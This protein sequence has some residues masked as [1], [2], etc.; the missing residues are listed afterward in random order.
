MC[1]IFLERVQKKEKKRLD[2]IFLH[3]LFS[4][5]LSILHT[6]FSFKDG[7]VLKIHHMWSSLLKRH[8]TVAL[9]ERVNVPIKYIP[10]VC[11]A[12]IIKLKEEGWV[13]RWQVWHSK[14]QYITLL[15]LSMRV[16]HVHF[17]TD[18]FRS[19]A[20][21]LA[22]ITLEQGLHQSLSQLHA[23]SS[24]PSSLLNKLL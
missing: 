13:G 19:P 17:N 14:V 18:P 6:R 4:F 10:R 11:N 1:P 22:L 7:S 5:F 23:I 2:I 16:L 8:L 20:N 21:T 12:T 3:T 24:L 15:A 9:T